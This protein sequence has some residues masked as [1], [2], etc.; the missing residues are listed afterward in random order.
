M[1]VRRGRP[2]KFGAKVAAP[3][4]PPSTRLSGACGRPRPRG[5]VRS[6]SLF[7][8]HSHHSGDASGILKWERRSASRSGAAPLV[9]GL[10]LGTLLENE[11]EACSVRGWRPDEQ[12]GPPSNLAAGRRRVS[13]SVPASWFTCCSERPPSAAMSVVILHFDFGKLWCW[14]AFTSP[15]P[16]PDS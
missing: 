1:R 4:R 12:V 13:P 16:L 8:S 6:R 9:L 15:P 10:G 5:P 2:A 14:F 11:N 7:C 3:G